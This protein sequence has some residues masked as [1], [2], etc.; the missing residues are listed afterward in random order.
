MPRRR[1]RYVVAAA[2]IAVIV[3]AVLGA[4]A[5][6][7][8]ADKRSAVEWS[9]LSDYVKPG[10]IAWLESNAAPDGQTYRYFARIPAS[11]MAPEALGRA[12]TDDHFL[13]RDEIRV[14]GVSDVVYRTISYFRDPVELGNREVAL[15]VGVSNADKALAG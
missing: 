2:A 7:S 5:A 14:D 3:V 6:W 11:R 1:R 13:L 9:G 15:L 4:R 8:E 10:D 12:A